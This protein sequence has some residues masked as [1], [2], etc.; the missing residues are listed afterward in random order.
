[1]T[2]Q[3]FPNSGKGWGGVGKF[4]PPSQSEI[5][6]WRGIFLPDEGNLRRSDFDD[7]N[8]F[9]SWKQLSVNTEHQLKS[10]LA[11]PVLYKEHGIKTKMLQEQLLQ[12]KMKFL[13][14][15][16]MKVVI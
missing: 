16:N 14:G 11:W 6:L 3:A 1:M 5:L 12:L 9:Q 8:L 7:P 15:Y 10:K 2:Y 13:L 4:C